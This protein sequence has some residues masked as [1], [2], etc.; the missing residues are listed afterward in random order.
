MNGQELKKIKV[1]NVG[2]PLIQEKK[3]WN[4]ARLSFKCP[5]SFK[6]CIIVS[7]VSWILMLF[8]GIRMWIKRYVKKDI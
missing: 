4:I 7:L 3:G 8:Y 1:S 5:E 6:L 2:T